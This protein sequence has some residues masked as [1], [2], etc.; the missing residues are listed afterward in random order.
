MTLKEIRENDEV[1]SEF[2]N[3]CGEILGGKAKKDDI[4]RITKTMCDTGQQE[5]MK[6]EFGKIA[7]TLTK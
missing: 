2:Y 6:I 1:L 3:L 5:I 4:K 7:E